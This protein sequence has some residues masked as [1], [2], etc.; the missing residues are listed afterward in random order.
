MGSVRTANERHNVPLIP[1]FCLHRH[2]TLRDLHPNP[3][4][5]KCAEDCFRIEASDVALSCSNLEID[6]QPL[7]PGAAV[8]ASGEQ[9][10]SV[11]NCTFINYNTGILA[12]NLSVFNFSYIAG[13]TI[14]EYGIFVKNS[15]NGVIANSVI[16]TPKNSSISLNNVKNTVVKQNTL[17][18]IG[19]GDVALLLNN[20]MQNSVY[21]NTGAYN[22][23]GLYIKGQSTNNT[24]QNNTM[25]SSASADYFCAAQDSGI[26]NES[27][28]INTGSVK[29][30]CQWMAMLPPASKPLF[31]SSFTTPQADILT[32]DYVYSYG[33]I[34]LKF[35]ATTRCS[36]ATDT[37]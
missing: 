25:T 22:N 30:G 10:V 6:A 13:N 37:R 5:N 11:R 32:Q 28:G 8:V 17:D 18:S 16:Q 29:A 27:G 19:N 31:C 33:A 9:N 15:D 3:K 1:D 20:S 35:I 36:T 4:H 12:S 23:Y 2:K 7:T 24:V 26:M 14:G 34:C 21:N